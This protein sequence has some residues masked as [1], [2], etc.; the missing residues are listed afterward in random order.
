MTIVAT[1]LMILTVDLVLD[2]L[3]LVLDV[4]SDLLGGRLLLLLLLLN[5]D[6]LHAFVSVSVIRRHDIARHERVV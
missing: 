2:L 6:R 5:D 1:V 3:Q 4:G